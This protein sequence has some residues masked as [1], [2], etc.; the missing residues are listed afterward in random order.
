M[1]RILK[2]YIIGIIQP[3]VDVVEWLKRSLVGVILENDKYGCL[4]S[5]FIYSGLDSFEF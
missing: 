1:T 3:T 2:C 4:E 5:N